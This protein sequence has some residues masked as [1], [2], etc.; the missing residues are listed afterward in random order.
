M[1]FGHGIA[2]LVNQIDFGAGH[3][4]HVSLNPGGLADIVS[5]PGSLEDSIGD[6]T[7]KQRTDGRFE[8][9]TALV[10]AVRRGDKRASRIW[11]SSVEA[12][13]AAIVSLI[14]VLDPER[15]ILGGGITRAGA[16]LLLPLKKFLD[17]FEWR[18][19]GSK[20][21]IVFARLGDRAGAF[22]AQEGA[23]PQS[24]APRRSRV[25]EAE[26][27]ASRSLRGTSAAPPGQYR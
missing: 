4:G 1:V 21:R 12:L 15:V 2:A 23:L 5:T 24:G 22:G 25:G 11:L 8:S 20:V 19:D 27:T 16:T 7:V 17:K 14:N 18:P 6:C 9:T 3:F 26:L 13:A 10:A